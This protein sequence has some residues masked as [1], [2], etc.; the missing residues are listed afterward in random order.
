MAFS[1]LERVRIR[2]YLGVPA[3]YRD[4]HIDIEGRINLLEADSDVED[5]ARLLIVAITAILADI[6]SNAAFLKRSQVE[7]I[8]KGD[9]KL[10]GW[11]EV[12]IKRREG[13]RLVLDLVTM[14]DLHAWGFPLNSVFGN[15]TGPVGAGGRGRMKMG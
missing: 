6:G 13:E 2:R 1:N 9:V 4:M 11:E 5:E 3:A 7:S 15:R 10:R 14:M 8:D 12:R